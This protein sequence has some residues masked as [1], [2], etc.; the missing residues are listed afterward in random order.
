MK[1]QY[2]L[3]LM[4]FIA[5]PA[6]AQAAPKAKTY[7]SFGE[8]TGELAEKMEMTKGKIW[9]KGEHV[10]L[11]KKERL[12]GLSKFEKRMIVLAMGERNSKDSVQEILE[13]FQS[14]DGYITYFSHNS[15]DREFAIVASY[16]GDNEFG[17][18]FEIKRL[19][20]GQDYKVLTVAAAISDG[21]LVDCQ[22]ED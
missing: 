9:Y 10:S 22:V 1:F 20:R 8:T 17:V 3:I 11:H 2:A 16:P 14:A 12:N 5:L 19:K 21:D 6:F 13:S 15:D 7:C 4:A 18:I